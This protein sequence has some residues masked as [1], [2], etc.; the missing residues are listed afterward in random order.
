MPRRYV[1]LSKTDARTN[2]NKFYEIS[3]DDQG[4]VT[5]RWGRVGQPGKSQVKGQGDAAFETVYR[6]KHDRGGYRKVDIA[7]Q[8]VDSGPAQPSL[9]EIAQ[10]DLGCEDPVVAALV[11]RLAAINRHQLLTLSGGQ[12]QIVDGQVRTPLGLVTQASI[13]QARRLLDQLEQQVTQDKLGRVYQE[14]LENYLM[15]VPQKVPA[16]RGWDT[17]FFSQFTTFSQQNDL[18]DQLENSVTM[19]QHSAVPA[20]QAGETPRLFQYQIEVSDDKK[21]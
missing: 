1:M 7:T 18:L 10:R 8:V 15:Q 13:R 14:A 6:E 16:R 19:A 9:K 20:P 12:I 5:A 11:E 2:E 3:M 4:V 17:T 21:L